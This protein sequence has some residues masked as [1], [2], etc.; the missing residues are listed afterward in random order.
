MSIHVE[1]FVAR[2]RGEYD[3]NNKRTH[4]GWMRINYLNVQHAYLLSTS[5]SE[6]RYPK[7]DEIHC[8]Q[9]RWLLSLV[10]SRAIK[11]M[12][13][14]A[15]STSEQYVR[16]L[17]C[18]TMPTSPSDSAWTGQNSLWSE[19]RILC[20]DE[21]LLPNYLDLEEG[22]LRPVEPS[23]VSEFQRQESPANNQF[24]TQRQACASANPCHIHSSSAPSP[25]QTADFQYPDKGSH[26]TLAI[27]RAEHGWTVSHNE[28]RDCSTF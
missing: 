11:Y 6:T 27:V 7:E 21:V 3:S 8:R 24:E 18:E 12:R 22:D 23:S 16:C 17:R 2:T 1:R 19:R 15:T 14:S 5:S 10:D 9:F 28:V 20:I 13:T 4:L 26:G 25:V